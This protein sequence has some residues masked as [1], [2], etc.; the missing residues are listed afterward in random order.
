MR[1]KSV[2]FSI[3]ALLILVAPAVAAPPPAPQLLPQRTLAYF[4]INN[5]S[6]L[7]KDFGKTAFGKLFKDPKIRPLIADLYKQVEDAFKQIEQQIGVSLTQI[8]KLPQGELSVA[9]VAPQ[10]GDMGL[11]MNLDVGTQLPAAKKLL[12]LFDNGVKFG[13][14][15]TST[16]KAGNIS[17][18]VSRPEP[19]SRSVDSLGRMRSASMSEPPKTPLP[20][21]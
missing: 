10:Q 9:L 11:V 8:M 2:T 21:L 19:P 1:A 5:C 4:R 18:K 12:K 16:E 6:Q 3:L 14:Y 15:K 13:G 20:R 7:S 17:P